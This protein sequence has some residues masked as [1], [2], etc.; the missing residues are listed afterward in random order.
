MSASG[1]GT[2]QTVI[3]VLNLAPA[4]IVSGAALVMWWAPSEFLYFASAAV[5]GFGAGLSGP[6]PTAYIADLAPVEVRARVF[7]YW[8]SLS[9]CG[10]VIGSIL[11]GY[12]GERAGYGVPLITTGAIIATSGVAFWL[13]APEFH[14]PNR[15][16]APAAAPARP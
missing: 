14:R 10:Y 4:T 12:L 15:A 3:T 5:W 13:F 6:A 11:M 2:A 8:R 1:I 16:Q 7:G 9:D